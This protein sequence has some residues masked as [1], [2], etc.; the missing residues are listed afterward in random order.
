MGEVDYD[1]III[2]KDSYGSVKHDL[3]ESIFKNFGSGGTSDP[4]NQR[5]TMGWKMS[6]AGRIL[7]D[8]FMHN[9][10]VTHS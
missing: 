2:G 6:W 4:L 8:T 9:L 7:N 10:K 1:V 5:A 3:V